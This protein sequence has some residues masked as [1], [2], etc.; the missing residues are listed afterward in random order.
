LVLACWQLELDVA[1]MQQQWASS[2]F[3]HVSRVHAVLLQLLKVYAA[4]VV[5]VR[6]SGIQPQLATCV[7]T[8]HP[9]PARCT[10]TL[11]QPPLCL[12]SQN[13]MD[14]LEPIQ[15]MPPGMYHRYGVLDDMDDDEDEPGGADMG[16]GFGGS[17]AYN[18]DMLVA[19][20]AGLG[21]SDD[22]AEGGEQPDG[23]E[24]GP[25]GSEEG[26]AGRGIGNWSLLAHPGGWPDMVLQQ[27]F[28]AGVM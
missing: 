2:C 22:A 1:G 7:C 13:D 5:E 8:A 16:D 28:V 14:A 18:A 19:G 17:G 25:A 20:M 9:V 6:V 11:L 21:V 27:W 23:A 15:G 3:A 10:A 4:F 24:E 26:G 12:C